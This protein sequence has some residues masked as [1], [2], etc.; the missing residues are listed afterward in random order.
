MPTAY[1][2]Y[3]RLFFWLGATTGLAQVPAAYAAA[4][5][6]ACPA[7]AP[8]SR[9]QRVADA[10]LTD[11]SVR[12]QRADVQ[13]SWTTTDEQRCLRFEVERSADGLTYTPIGRV[14]AS[15]TTLNTRRNYAFTDPSA[16]ALRGAPSYYRLVVVDTDSSR[17][18]S[19]SQQLAAAKV[20]EP[21]PR[22]LLFPNPC[23]PDYFT[24]NMLLGI[25]GA[26]AEVEVRVVDRLGR[27]RA[28]GTTDIDGYAQLPLQ[29]GLA[30]GLYVVRCGNKFAHLIIA[31]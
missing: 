27:V 30:T 2:F 15:I 3:R 23:S 24:G 13:L 28:S 11:F 18:Y 22:P 5:A 31:E 1:Q 19:P 21:L 29:F 4:P 8:Q 7:A 14:R 10:S 16:R 9:P 20:V 25:V 12:R 26:P 6:P 17:H